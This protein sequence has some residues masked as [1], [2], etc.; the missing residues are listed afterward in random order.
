MKADKDVEKKSIEDFKAAT[1]IVEQE[2][3]LAEEK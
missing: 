1:A 3:K 2:R